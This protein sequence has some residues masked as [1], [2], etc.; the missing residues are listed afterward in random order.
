MS[1]ENPQEIER[2]EKINKQEI[3]RTEKINKQELYNKYYRFLLLIPGIILL[4]SLIFLFNF[5]QTNNDFIYKDVTL[6]GGTSIT[7]NDK[8]SIQ[9]LRTALEGKLEDFR[10]KEVSDL[11]TGE[12]IAFIVETK[13]DSESTQNILEDYLGYELTTENSSIEFTGSTLGEDFYKQLLIAILFSFLLM[14]AVVFIIFRTLVPSSAVIISAFSDITMTLALVNYFGM[15]LS[16]AGIIAFLMIIGYSVD[17]DILLATRILK[18]R[19]K[20]LNQRIGDALKTGVTMTLTSLVAVLVALYI[21]KSFSSVLSQIFTILSIGLSF[22]LL[23]TW[24]TNA[25]ILKWYVEYKQ[26]KKLK[27][28]NDEI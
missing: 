23:N 24:F 27:K 7:V 11:R 17:T 20:T 4:I 12:Q 22:D 13:E 15:K 2:T 25:S 6:T 26:N 8:I 5:Y 21:T 18:R 28:Q 10:V 19:E 9:E 3:E 16:S 1:E 14:A